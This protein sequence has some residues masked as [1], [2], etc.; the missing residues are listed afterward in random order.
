MGR[1]LGYLG[2]MRM[3][4]LIMGSVALLW[5]LLSM[6]GWRLSM[7]LTLTIFV[8]ALSLMISWLLLLELQLQLPVLLVLLMNDV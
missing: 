5:M 6:L 2:H 3:H 8:M 7:G 4:M 1:A